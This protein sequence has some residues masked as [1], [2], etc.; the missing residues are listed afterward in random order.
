[1]FR[2]EVTKVIVGTCE[3]PSLH[4]SLGTY[5]PDSWLYVFVETVCNGLKSAAH[6]QKQAL[7]EKNILSKIKIGHKEAL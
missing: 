7:E 6:L 5:K 3:N 2:C 4:E 1:M